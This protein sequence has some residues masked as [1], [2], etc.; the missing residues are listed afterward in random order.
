MLEQIHVQFKGEGSGPEPLS[1]GQ[2]AQWKAIELDGRVASAGGTMALTNGATVKQLA[3]MLGLIVSRHEALRTVVELDDQGVPHQRVLDSGD[4]V[5][6][7]RHLED[8]ED[9]A[10]VAEEISDGYDQK[11]WDVFK[12]DSVRMAAVCRDG[13]PS[14]FVAM[15]NHFFIDG[16]GI[17]AISRDLANLDMENGRQ[18]ASVTGMTP[19][20][21]ARSQQTASAER[22]GR[23]SLRHWENTMRNMPLR[24]FGDSADKRTP[25]Y[26]EATYNSPAAH[27]AVQVLMAR[28]S[29]HSSV[30]ILA[31]YARALARV[32]GKDMIVLRSLVSNRYRPGLRESV[33][34][35]AQSG[36]TVIDATE[37][38]FEEMADRA[39]R[40]QVAGGRH[41]YYDPR[42][43]WALI[44]RVAQERGESPDLKVYYSDRRR[45]K[46]LGLGEGPLPTRD[47]A[48]AALPRSTLTVG[49][50]G[51]GPGTTAFFLVNVAKDAIEYEMSYDTH[52]ISPAQHEAILREVEKVLVDAAFPLADETTAAQ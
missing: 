33:S 36:L 44:D 4:L 11:G 30:L 9:P 32:S 47:Q 7:V 48:L 22:Q 8:G 18:L 25:R 24:L 35:V 40:A 1:W 21:Q 29:L 42:E 6:E 39:F 52:R 20:E 31:A 50:R 23:V 12:Y 38:S 2:W 13:K 49:A 5:L 43:L 27:L 34:A 26:W 19:I 17:D 37:C 28:T 46:A 10:A 14:H 15:Y 51:D 3:N 45:G 41:G 16:S